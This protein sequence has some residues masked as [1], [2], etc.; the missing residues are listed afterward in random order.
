MTGIYARTGTF[1]NW[2]QGVVFF[3]N[4]FVSYLLATDITCLHRDLL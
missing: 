3:S 2:H 4:C 1:E